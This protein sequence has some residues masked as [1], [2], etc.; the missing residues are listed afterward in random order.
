[1]DKKK[2]I[3]RILVP[4]LIVVALAA[5]WAVKN[6]VFPERSST[7]TSTDASEETEPNDDFVLEATSLNLDALKE[8][9]LPIMIDFGADYC[10]PCKRMAP[11]LVAI[12]EKMQGKAIIKFV[13][14]GKSREIAE[15]YPISVVPTQIFFEPDGSPYVPSDRLVSNLGLVFDTYDYKDTGEHA[16]TIHQGLLTE[17][18]IDAILTDMEVSD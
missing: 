2:L 3:A 11:T 18:E 10:D 12:N 1:M 13:D 9:H 16:L 17:D 8:Y 7:D 6:G 14:I 5:I 15:N 4:L